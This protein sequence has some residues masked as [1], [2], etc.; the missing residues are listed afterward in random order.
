MAERLRTIE[1][2]LGA[3][4]ELLIGR[5]ITGVKVEGNGVDRIQKLRLILDDGTVAWISYWASY[6]D[7]DCLEIEIEKRR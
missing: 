2:I 1:E 6:S 5:T 7:D 4:P 3:D